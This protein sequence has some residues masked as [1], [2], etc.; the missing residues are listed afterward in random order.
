MKKIPRSEDKGNVEPRE[1]ARRE[2]FG[3]RCN[4]ALAVYSFPRRNSDSRTTSS[5]KR[6]T[7]WKRRGALILNFY[8]TP[9]VPPTDAVH[10]RG[11]AILRVSLCAVL[12]SL[13]V[14]KWISSLRV[15]RLSTGRFKNS[16]VTITNG[17]RPSGPWIVETWKD[18]IRNDRGSLQCNFYTRCGSY[19]AIHLFRFWFGDRSVL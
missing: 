17:S 11:T 9:I 2:N 3:L 16:G 5:A 19:R 10:P 4:R 14:E 15:A 12:Y 13:R 6:T 18:R 8:L 1:K 7:N